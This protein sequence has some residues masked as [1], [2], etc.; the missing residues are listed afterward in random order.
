MLGHAAYCA[1]NRPQLSS[2][3]PKVLQAF[4]S[5]AAAFYQR[6]HV[7]QQTNTV[8]LLQQP[9]IVCSGPSRASFVNRAAGK[10][11]KHRWSPARRIAQCWRNHAPLARPHALRLAVHSPHS[12]CLR[13]G[14][15]S[16]LPSLPWQ[17]PRCLRPRCWCAPRPPYAYRSTPF[18][19]CGAI[20]PNTNA[21]QLAAP[22]A[23]LHR[24]LAPSPPA[25]PQQL[26]DTE[27]RWKTDSGRRSSCRPTLW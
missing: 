23:I 13:R 6:H 12:V 16:V 2:P 5:A 9:L 3:W 1:S 21:V 8:D 15:G 11:S 25:L 24:P 10:A 22:A 7:N 20:P 4:C 17:L 18:A 26:F 27:L 19:G 14:I